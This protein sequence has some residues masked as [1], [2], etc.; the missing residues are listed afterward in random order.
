M[1]FQ[2]K[3]TWEAPMT[4]TTTIRNFD[5]VV[6]DEPQPFGG[7]D[8]GASPME[9]VTAALIG[10][11]GITL[12]VVSRE[13]EFKFSNVT[14]EMEGQLDLRGFMGMPGVCRHFCDLHGTV[15]LET[16]ESEERINEV[17][18]LVENRCPVS[19]LLTDAG[20]AANIIWKKK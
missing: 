10:C 3:G 18:E 15:V 6:M 16:E 20:V 2:A 4:V 12:S 11:I 9:Y 19:N 14:M 17:K 13:K 1:T 7:A 5:P 8:K